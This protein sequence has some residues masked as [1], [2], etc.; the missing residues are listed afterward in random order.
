MNKQ[1]ELVENN[2]SILLELRGA[3]RS[4]LELIL[5]EK[6]KM[7]SCSPGWSKVIDGAIASLVALQ[8]ILFSNKEQDRK[9]P[10]EMT[11]EIYN[12]AGLSKVL[13]L[14]QSYNLGIL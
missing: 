9:S 11:A 7:K 4:I 10:E 14:N 3:G 6:D 13:Q 2:F 1:F 5:G 8:W 12:K